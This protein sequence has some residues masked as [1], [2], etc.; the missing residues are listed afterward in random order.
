MFRRG[1]QQQR[2]KHKASY[3]RE[4]VNH[5]LSD[6]K[7]YK[8]QIVERALQEVFLKNNGKFPGIPPLF[9]K[10]LTDI[11]GLSRSF[12]YD[13]IKQEALLFEAKALKECLLSANFWL[14]MCRFCQE[15]GL[16][17]LGNIFRNNA[18]KQAYEYSQSN[19]ATITDIVVALKASIDQGDYD[20][21][22]QILNKLKSKLGS[23]S[24]FNAF[25][26]FLTVT[27][28][29][30]NNNLH[31]EGSYRKAK[32][33]LY[34]SF[35]C[36]RSVA[37]LGPAPGTV[38][39]EE[40]YDSF[41]IVVS[42]NY[43]GYDQESSLYLLNSNVD[44]SYYNSENS[45]KIQEDNNCVFFN[46]LRFA[47]FRSIRHEFQKNLLKQN[48]SR[49]MYTPNFF[50]FNGH[51]QLVQNVVYDILHFRPHKLKLFNVNFFTSKS[52]YH[53]GYSIND[54]K[55][56]VL[57]RW[58]SFADHDL[59]SQLCFTRN[60]WRNG[61]I[62]VDDECKKVLNMSNTEYISIIEDVFARQKHFKQ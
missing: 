36:G 52:S 27:G 25:V 58:N 10:Q 49:V 29:F 62:G 13:E 55:K 24:D 4:V 19:K 22:K 8:N 2:F 23:R 57:W 32:E 5:A 51:A 6:Q 61:C 45:A 56:H 50:L 16:F 18:I 60:L 42:L 3:L 20:A 39:I 43:R 47:V 31:L 35:I 41:D 33:Q 30:P 26:R 37:V 34:Q 48:K 14:L 59:I 44:I 54:D 17:V 53:S 9:I 40:I 38:N 7:S 28:A 1:R 21:S 12:S 11:I 46:H 15:N